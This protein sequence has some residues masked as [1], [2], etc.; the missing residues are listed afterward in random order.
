MSGYCQ[1]F[2]YEIVVHFP[3]ILFHRPSGFAGRES[4][5]RHTCVVLRPGVQDAPE[6]LVGCLSGGFF[7]A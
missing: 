6:I 2:I 3:L 4:P 1:G 7:G 5:G